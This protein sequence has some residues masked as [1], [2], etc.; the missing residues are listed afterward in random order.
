MVQ[1]LER[2][3]SSLRSL[4]RYLLCQLTLILLVA[5]LLEGS[6]AGEAQS[7]KNDK[8]RPK[9]SALRSLSAPQVFQKFDL[10]NFGSQ[11]VKFGRLGSQGSLAAL[12]VQINYEREITCLTALSL[13]SGEVLWQ[14]GTPD[15]THYKSTSDVPIQVFDWNQDGTDDVIFAQGG[16]IVVADGADG[17]AIA[18]AQAETPYS[19]FVYETEQFG[20]LAGVVLHGRTSTT[21]LGPDLTVAWTKP[22]EFSHFP[23]AIDVD[24]DN[25]PELLAGY[26]LFRSNGD[27]L[28]DRRDLGAH[29]D[30]ADFA[31]VDC[32]GQ[33]DV[34]IATSG[35]SALL[36]RDGTVLWRGVEHHSQHITIGSF[37]PGRCERQIATIDRDHEK[38]GI[39]RLYGHKGKLLWE[40]R[41]HG[42]KAMMTR[43]DDW[44]PQAE[45][46]LILVFRSFTQPPTLYDGR[47][48]LVGRLP[49]PP[50][51]VYGSKGG[52][53]TK[54]Y[55]Q[56]FDT[57]GDGTEEILLYNERALWV[58]GNSA[59]LAARAG[60]KSSQGL[61]NPRI[62]N[63][64]FYMGMQ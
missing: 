25:E 45:E 37:L 27:L 42:S 50:A 1:P 38:S 44:I 22:N 64:T 47:G 5:I 41:G 32:D 51:A 36:K 18:S 2:A 19:L 61:P 43:I 53:Y 46:S 56:H 58:Y 60:Q 11:V 33:R 3:A 21:L 17:T 24:D 8:S 62:F 12:F 55:A 26:R 59:A 9:N 23:M 63:A 10:K 20:G 6:T 49:F 54:H 35:K 40:S 29:N 52:L 7:L 30:A 16:S 28:W 4:S 14:L 48:A 39:L 31:D 15:A 13:D 57:D 34:A